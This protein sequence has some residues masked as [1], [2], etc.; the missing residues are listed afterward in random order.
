[1]PSDTPGPGEGGQRHPD[2][3]AV[4]LGGSGAGDPL[5]SGCRQQGLWSFS[6][7]RLQGL[8]QL[9][10]GGRVLPTT[11]L[12]MPPKRRHWPESHPELENAT[13]LGEEPFQH[14]FRRLPWAGGG[15]RQQGPRPCPFICA[16]EGNCRGG[17]LRR[18]LLNPPPCSRPRLASRG[19]GVARPIK[20]DLNLPGPEGEAPS[21]A[22]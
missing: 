9:G 12:R 6:R 10:G 20:S 11:G 3:R 2:F 4:W 15:G 17:S 8:R 18:N 13:G 22:G 14:P 21:L 16:S 19:P 5:A 7:R 1:M